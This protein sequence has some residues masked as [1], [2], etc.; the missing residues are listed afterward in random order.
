MEKDSA[1]TT[2]QSSEIRAQRSLQPSAQVVLLASL[3][4][5]GQKFSKEIEIMFSV[6]LAMMAETHNPDVMALSLMRA[7]RIALQLGVDEED[8][9]LCASKIVAIYDKMRKSSAMSTLF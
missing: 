5:D 3:I 8:F 1:L 9:D 4:Q 2:R 7:K 6:L